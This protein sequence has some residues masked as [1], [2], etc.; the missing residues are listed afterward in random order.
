MGVVL[1]IAVLGLVGLTAESAPSLAPQVPVPPARAQEQP[2]LS[3]GAS[4]TP[5]AITS[6][7]L[8]REVFVLT[9]RNAGRSHIWA[10]VVGEPNAYQLT[11]GDWDDQNPVVSPGM[12]KIAFASRKSGYWNLY[13]LE[14]DTGEVRQLTDTSGYEGKPTW[15]PDGL[16]VAYEAYYGDNF[17]IWILPVDGRQSP[18]QLTNDPGSDTAP[19]WDPKGRR[20]AFTSDRGGSPDIYQADLDRPTDRFS[21]LTNTPNIDEFDPAFNLDG[22]QIAFSVQIDGIYGIQRMRTDVDGA[23]FAPQWVGQGSSP[24]WS[25]NGKSIAGILN[26]PYAAHIVIYPLEQ[27]LRQG[28]GIL[29]GRIL[30][31]D[32]SPQVLLRL[33]AYPAVSTEQRVQLTDSPAQSLGDRLGLV[34]LAGITPN[35]LRLSDAADEAFDALRRRVLDQS[36][37]DFLSN[38]QR[39]YVGLNEPLPPGY[40]YNDWLYTGRAFLISQAAVQAEWVEVV[41]EEFG[42]ETYWRVYVRASVQDGSLGEPLKTAP[43]DFTTRY[44]GDPTAYDAGG[45]PKPNI[46]DG[47]YV[48]FTVLAADYGFQRVQALPNWRSFYPGARFDE[49]ALREG[50]DWVTAMQE[51]YPASAIATPTPYQ[52][53][54]TTPTT[55]PRPTPTP[56]WWRWRTPTPTFEQTPTP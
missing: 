53:P 21:N 31:M 48:D 7:F 27:S 1:L 4:S 29:P 28:I 24:A 36:G 16:W 42:L 45:G 32:W 55:T 30:D 14:L 33:D 17:D 47:Y 51:L 19:T 23:Q 44:I 49:F 6:D 18:I 35:G 50:L 26:T 46:P 37:W 43:W 34:P 12:D 10:Q 41:L 22:T 56:W 40:A 54:T 3:D 39:A 38:L 9:L 11:E 25:G 8:E 20:I 13:V 52:T 5:A 2:L 15:S